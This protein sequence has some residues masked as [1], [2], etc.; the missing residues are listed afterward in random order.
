M[1]GGRRV[2]WFETH[3]RCYS[4]HSSINTQ[5][6]KSQSLSFD[7]FSQLKSQFCLT[8]IT[9]H[10]ITFIN[11][12]MIVSLLLQVFLSFEMLW[13]KRDATW[14]ILVNGPCTQKLEAWK[15]ETSS[16]PFCSSTSNKS[17]IYCLMCTN[18]QSKGLL[19]RIMLYNCNFLFQA[20]LKYYR[21]VAATC[22]MFRELTDIHD[23][24]D[25]V[26]GMIQYFGDDPG[27][28]SLVAGPGAWNDPDQVKQLLL[29][30]CLKASL[31]KKCNSKAIFND[32]W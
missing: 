29:L 10:H 8:G 4:C 32:A 11:T 13:I 31:P 9:S 27:N 17:D 1:C 20:D 22:N 24:W 25:S 26:I 21:T 28:F 6:L 2:N 23:S 12:Y 15:Y 5:D 14:F 16:W 19:K 18:S 30:N 7:L 3:F